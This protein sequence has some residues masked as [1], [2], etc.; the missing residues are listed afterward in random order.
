MNIFRLA[1]DMSHVVSILILILRLRVS[2]SAVGISLK[3]QELFLLVFVTRYLDLFTTYYSLYNSFMKVAYVTSTAF[4]IYMI[5]F[6]EPY[7]SK[8]DKSQD[9]FLHWKFAVAP[10]AA[11]AL[12]VC[13]VK[14]EKN[15][16]DVLWTFSIFLESL[17]I[18][19]QL[20]VLQ[21]YREVENLTGHYVFFLG[22]YRGLY[23]LNWVYRSYYEQFYR[24]NWLV[25]VCGAVQTALYVDF[26]YY[27]VISKYYGGKLTLPT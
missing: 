20:F 11:L 17:A 3:T 19:P 26:F 4:I 6:K 2:K 9:S 8:Y 22:A 27:Y 15:P 5:R 14:R 7:R 1:G 12:L 23:I 24:H 10:C 25:Y 13:L 21:R 18:V 16:I